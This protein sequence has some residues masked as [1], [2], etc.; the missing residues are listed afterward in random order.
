MTSRLRAVREWAAA[1]GKRPLL[2]AA[3][4]L[5]VATCTALVM[6][7]IAGF[8]PVAHVVTHFDGVWLL[9]IVAG[10]ALCYLGYTVAYRAT[11]RLRGGPRL[12]FGQALGLVAAGFGVFVVGG[13]FAVDRRALRGLGHSREQARV[14]V[15]GLGALEYA[16]LAPVAWICALLLLDSESVDDGLLLTWVIAVPVGTLI[17]LWL[18]YWRHRTRVGTWLRKTARHGVAA[19]QMVSEIATHRE[20]NPAWMGIGVYWLGELLSTWAGLRL[21]GINLPADKLVLA[22]ATGYAMTPRGLPLAG[23]GV[24]EVLMPLAYTW[25]GVP[26][27]DA[28]LAVFAYRIV[29]LVIGLVPALIATPLVERFTNERSEQRGV[30]TP[31]LKLKGAAAH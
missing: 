31:S 5:L 9:V 13:G 22:Y 3:V 24:T 23:V 15:L 2:L 16:V 7:I 17:A 29:T 10:R 25:V 27:A 19:L 18:T 1:L 11:M 4:A 30:A 8:G 20:H 26:L 12:S 21:F 28:V 14:R 6:T